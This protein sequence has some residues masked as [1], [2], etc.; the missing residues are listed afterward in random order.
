MHVIGPT[1]NQA[2][3]GVS[4]EFLSA[5]IEKSQELS[6][7]ALHAIREGIRPGMTE[8]DASAMARDVLESMG[9]PRSWHRPLIRFGVNTTKGFSDKSEGDG[10]LK[11]NDIYFLDLGPNWVV[12]GV[13]YEGDVGN[14]FLI[15]EAIFLKDC[16]EASRELFQYAKSCWKEK[17]LTGP[18]LY[19]A[20]ETETN[21]LGFILLRKSDGHRLSE[22]PHQNYTRQ[23][24]TEI[25][26]IPAAHRWILEVQ[27]ADPDMR[28][29]A[30]YEDLLC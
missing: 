16:V 1:E 28:F 15:G 22:F 25:D 4:S 9:S 11:E 12:D 7:K 5:G 30:F 23:G 24:L 3:E 10:R 27:I 21:R 13:E 17:K 26:F 2:I 20:L 8:T 6:W 29:G 18:A 14:T 19:N